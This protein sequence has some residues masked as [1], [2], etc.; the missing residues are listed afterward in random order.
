MLY[1]QLVVVG[2]LHMV[3]MSNVT[4]KKLTNLIHFIGITKPSHVNK[5]VILYLTNVAY[6]LCCHSL[7]GSTHGSISQWQKQ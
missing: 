6:A 4:D 3:L 5:H 1:K 7:Y 2:R